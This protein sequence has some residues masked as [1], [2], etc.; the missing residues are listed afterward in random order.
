[1]LRAKI[2]L[3]ERPTTETLLA[4]ER[5]LLGID[6]SIP[7]GIENSQILDAIRS[8]NKKTNGGT[9]YVLLKRIGE[10]MNPDGDHQ[11]FVDS[12]IVLSVLD[13]YKLQFE[14]QGATV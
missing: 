13:A 3:E 9:K 12:A 8:D 2:D 4:L 10:C 5:K 1:M 6:L 7:A 14:K 11:V